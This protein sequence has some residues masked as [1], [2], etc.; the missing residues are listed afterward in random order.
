MRS[1]TTCCGDRVVDV[2]GGDQDDA[3]GDGVR[4][5]PEGAADALGQQLAELGGD[6]RRVSRTRVA[7]GNVWS[8][9]RL[10]LRSRWRTCG[11]S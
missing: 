6:R 3:V 8:V 4:H 10:P 7:R 1:A 11:R 9:M 5:H 2:G